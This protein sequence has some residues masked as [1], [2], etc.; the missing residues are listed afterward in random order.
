L[1][2]ARYPMHTTYI[3]ADVPRDATGLVLSTLRQGLTLVPFRAQLEDHL[4]TSLTLELNLS[5]FGTHPRVE[6]GYVGDR[7]SLI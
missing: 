2:G 7:V 4:A 6:L 5:T 1:A 3:S